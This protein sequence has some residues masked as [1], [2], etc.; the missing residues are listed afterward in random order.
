VVGRGR[1]TSDFLLASSSERAV[2][3]PADTREDVMWALIAVK[4]WAREAKRSS[5]PTPHP[6]SPCVRYLQSLS[7]A[8]RGPKY[9]ERD[10]VVGLVMMG[11]PNGRASSSSGRSPMLELGHLPAGAAGLKPTTS[12]PQLLAGDWTPATPLPATCRLAVIK[13]IPRRTSAAS[14]PTGL[15]AKNDTLL[16]TRVAGDESSTRDALEGREGGR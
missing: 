16:T 6:A 15:V 10:D 8:K 1:R 11:T 3:C 2:P 12:C 13:G 14:N 9:S 4:S 7:A 5:L